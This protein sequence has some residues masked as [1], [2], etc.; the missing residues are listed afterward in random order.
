MRI[1]YF[2]PGSSGNNTGKPYEEG[3]QFSHERKNSSILR[4]ITRKLAKH[5]AADPGLKLWL[6]IFSA[7]LFTDEYDEKDEKLVVGEPVR[8]AR[9]YLSTNPCR[10]FSEIWFMPLVQFVPPVR[11]WPPDDPTNL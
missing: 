5:Y 9:E 6:L 4:A 3:V 1:A 10:P 8:Q 2:L 11:V 7:S